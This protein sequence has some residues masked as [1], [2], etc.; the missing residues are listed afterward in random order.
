MEKT[1]KAATY[2]LGLMF[3]VVLVKGIM[4][5]KFND[6]SMP[7]SEDER[8]MASIKKDLECLALNIYK[9]G[10]YEPVEGRIAIAQVTMNR[11]AHPQFPNSVCEVVYQ[12]NKVMERVIC[13]FSWYC[14]STHR[15]RAVNERAYDE[16]YEVAKKVL[17]ENFRLSSLEDALFYHAD[18]VNPRWRYER[19][20]KIGR[21]IFYKPRNDIK[22]AGI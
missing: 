13:Q 17:L 1:T 10:G 5:Y 19:I 6:Y 18:Y 4:L 8:T 3:V 22:V 2:L 11:V 20:E 15:N 9:E 12:K 16:S 21:H 14:D 7:L